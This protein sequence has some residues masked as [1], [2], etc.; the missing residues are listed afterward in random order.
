MNSHYDEQKDE[1]DLL[2]NILFDKLKI[3]QDLPTFSLEITITATIDEPKMEFILLV[4]LPEEYPTVSPTFT[5]TEENNYLATA[6]L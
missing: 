2:Q 5:L 3:V 6:K 1:V 4:D